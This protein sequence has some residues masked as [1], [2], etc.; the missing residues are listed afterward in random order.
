MKS[1]VSAIAAAVLFVS[2]IFTGSSYQAVPQI[3]TSPTAATYG[4]T[5]FSPIQGKT[6]YLAG[7]GITNTQN[8]I[9]LTSFTLPDPNNTPI[10]NSMFSGTQYGVLEAQT[11]KIENISYTGVTENANGSATL[12]GVQR[13]LSFYTPYAASTTL[14]LSHAGGASFILSNP[15]AFY[16]NNFAFLSNDQT[17]TGVNTYTQSPLYPGTYSPLVATP[18][19]A[20][21]AA[22]KGYV[23]GIAISGG[24]VATNSVPG[25]S[26][27]ATAAQAAAS[28]ATALYNSVAYSFFLPSSIATSTPGNTGTNVIPVT[29]TSHHISQNFL[30]LTVPWL[31]SGTVA[32]GTT[33][34]NAKLN[35]YNSNGST[36]SL[37]VSGLTPIT[38]VFT[39]NGTYTAPAGLVYASVTVIGGGAGGASFNNSSTGGG[40]GG[41]GSSAFGSLVCAVGAGDNGAES[42][43]GGAGFS[44][45][46]GRL[47]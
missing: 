27:L 13:G 46:R 10:T 7:A 3:K 41:G 25:I 11:S 8:T 42:S 38:Q 19:L 16:G 18:T 37:Q 15:A 44:F 30:D 4:T 26:F 40:G 1:I 14:A 28:T 39:S 21:Q 2:S 43:G 22:N 33:T 47:S 5:G 29:D 35:I 32:I 23:D 34:P 6:Y 36:P 31:F 45:W 20:G 9:Q 12:T 24:V 17:F